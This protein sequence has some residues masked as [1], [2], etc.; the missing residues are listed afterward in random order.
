LNDIAFID[1]R[2]LSGDGANQYGTQ[3]LTA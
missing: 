2:V 3:M 1:L